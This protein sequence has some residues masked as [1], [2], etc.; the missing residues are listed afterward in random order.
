M[1]NERPLN[2]TVPLNQIG[3]GASGQEISKTS[4]NERVQALSIEK[5]V[6]YSEALTQF[7]NENPDYY[8]KAYGV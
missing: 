7:R 4:L 8:A 2:S 3:H 1:F 5:G 6:S